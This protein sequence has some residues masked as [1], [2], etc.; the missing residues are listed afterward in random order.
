MDFFYAFCLFPHPCS[1]LEHALTQPVGSPKLLLLCS[2]QPKALS[3]P[4][5]QT[6]SCHCVVKQ[7]GDSLKPAETFSQGQS[8]VARRI[9]GSRAEVGELLGHGGHLVIR[10]FF[11]CFLLS[12]VECLLP[13]SSPTLEASFQQCGK[14]HAD[15]KEV[16]TSCHTRCREQTHVET[17]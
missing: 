11:V 6:L 5:A 17:L 3:P 2:S 15:S 4:G 12:L 1:L 14:Q 7:M 8:F 13:C 16:P 9:C 10:N